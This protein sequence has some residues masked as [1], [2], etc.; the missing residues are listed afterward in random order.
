MSD[1]GERAAKAYSS[2][3]SDHMIDSVV[4]AAQISNVQIAEAAFMA[5]L[6]WAMTNPDEFKEWC[7]NQSRKQ[8]ET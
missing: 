4:F 8:D 6:R 1:S 3:Y 7:D 5:A 2:K